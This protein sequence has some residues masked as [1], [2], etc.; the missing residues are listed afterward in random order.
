MIK[1][2][3]WY[4]GQIKPSEDITI[5]PND[6][7]LLRGYGLFD[8]FRTYNGKPF[9]WDWYWQRFKGSADLL[10]IPFDMKQEEVSEILAE[11]YKLSSAEEVAYRFLLTGGD[12]PDSSTMTKP[13]FLIRSEKLS[14]MPSESFE[15]GISIISHEYS[16]D[17][18]TLKSTDYKRVMSLQPAIKAAGAVDVLYHTGGLLSEM[19]RSNIFLV[20]DNQIK[21]P[22]TGVLRGI[23]RRT[24]ME[25]AKSDFE[26]S[27]TDLFLKDIFEADEVF[28][29][30]TNKKVL[31]VTKIDNV[32]IGNGAAGAASKEMLARFDEFIVNW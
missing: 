2:H 7:G 9:Q 5:S 20:K 21:T 22:A 28:T 16:R 17:M 4:N 24:V 30:S 13:N 26:V 23:T 31:P 32:S 3:S 29:T 18:P 1:S 6:L 19:S 25:L 12:A 8:Y 10:N 15:K 11:L 27:E 14:E